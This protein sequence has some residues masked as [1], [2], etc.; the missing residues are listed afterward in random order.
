[1]TPRATNPARAS[2]SK[3]LLRA[4]RSPSTRTLIEGR[5]GPASFRLRS[6]PQELSHLDRPEPG[7]RMAGRD[8]DRF[9][10]AAGLDHVEAADRLLRVR[11]RPVGDERLAAA[12]TDGSGSLR[13]RHLV[14]DDPRVP[15]LEI[16]Q[17]G[18]ALGLLRP[19]RLVVGVH[20]LGVPADQ[21]QVLHRWLLSG[22][23]PGRRTPRPEID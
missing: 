12:D 16:V 13:R 17:P 6:A 19:R 11:E 10:E 14:A 21:Q 2:H 15:R 23:S 9:L 18:E 5:T 7:D 20:P 4:T 8:L 22:L 1:M 3:P